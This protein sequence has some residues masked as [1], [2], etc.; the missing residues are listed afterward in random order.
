MQPVFDFLL[1]IRPVRRSGFDTL[2]IFND[3]CIYSLL[4]SAVRA[5]SSQNHPLWR[6]NCDV[7]FHGIARKALGVAGCGSAFPK[8]IAFVRTSAFSIDSP[9]NISN[10]SRQ[11]SLRRCL[12]VI[13]YF[14]SHLHT[15]CAFLQNA[16]EI[17]VDFSRS[18]RVLLKVHCDTKFLG[19]ELSVEQRNF[20]SCCRKPKALG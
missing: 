10:C 14:P 7:R 1:P 11:V 12:K 3:F 5:L 15:P 9:M 20:N 8:P 19:I 18:G 16:V 4:D 2:F 17:S 6:W 13:F